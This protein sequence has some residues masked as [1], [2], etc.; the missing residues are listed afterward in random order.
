M[1]EPERTSLPKRGRRALA[2]HRV[3]AQRRR[4]AAPRG[5]VMRCAAWFLS[6]IESY[7]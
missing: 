5:T 4:A 2:A 6:A 1:Q 3:E 7:P